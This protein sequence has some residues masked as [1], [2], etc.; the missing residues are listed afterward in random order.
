MFWVFPASH[1][2]LFWHFSIKKYTNFR[3]QLNFDVSYSCIHDNSAVCWKSH[4]LEIGWKQGFLPVVESEMK[5]QIR[6]Q[7]GSSK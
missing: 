4:G 5:R 2:G 3:P 1:W 7:Q 6:S